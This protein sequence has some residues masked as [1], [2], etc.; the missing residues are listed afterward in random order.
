M[1][2]KYVSNSDGTGIVPLDSVSLTPLLL[3]K[4]KAVRDPDTGY[5][6]T[7]AKDLMKNGRCV[8]GAQNA[9]Y[10]VVCT[11]SPDNCEFYNLDKDPLEEYPLAK[12]ESCADYVNG[13]W[14]PK[15]PQWHYCR[16][17]EV[18]AKESFIV[19]DKK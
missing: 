18:V 14:T 13:K 7:E 16:L 11:D 17:T 12:P 15:D 5:M 10:K 4:E 2:P 9:T 8:V 3:N 19:A 1:S 6:L